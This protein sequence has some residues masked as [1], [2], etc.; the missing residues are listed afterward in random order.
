[1]AVGIDIKVRGGKKIA[2]ELKRIAS[3]G[4]G[5]YPGALAAGVYQ[6]GL[7]VDRASVFLT[8]VAPEFGG[9]LRGSHYVAPPTGPK[10]EVE[11]GNGT[12]YAVPQHEGTEFEH[13][14]GEAKF[15]QK[16]VNL[17]RR[18]YAGMLLRLTQKNFKAKRGVDAITK[19]APTRPKD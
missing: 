12:V 16:A 2:K 11:V 9:T 8:P 4:G 14:T 6:Q 18:N 3:A 17:V 5:G 7:R 13:T 1:M 10:I 15:L 19:T